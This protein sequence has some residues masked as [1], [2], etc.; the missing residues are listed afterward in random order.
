MAP[1][2]RKLSM[3]ILAGGM[4]AGS[5]LIAACSS[6]P[7]VG[8]N[9][10]YEAG[11]P[12]TERPAGLTCKMLKRHSRLPGTLGLPGTLRYGL[13]ES[14]KATVLSCFAPLRQI[15]LMGSD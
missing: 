7:F 2:L 9:E 14:T 15:Q 8:D 6:I 4:V 11:K 10:E 12:P 5:P 1:R 13:T 3:A